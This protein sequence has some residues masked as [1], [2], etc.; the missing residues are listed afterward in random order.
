M[1]IAPGRDQVIAFVTLADGEFLP[2]NLNSEKVVVFRCGPSTARE[3]VI[4][5][6]FGKLAEPELLKAPVAP[7]CTHPRKDHPLHQH[8]DNSWWYYDNSWTF[9]Y[10]PFSSME[11]AHAELVEYC[12]KALAADELEENPQ[13]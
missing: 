4:I 13:S 11:L 12:A 2:A 6:E 7:V 8:S 5:K 1:V 9:E 10:G 3:L